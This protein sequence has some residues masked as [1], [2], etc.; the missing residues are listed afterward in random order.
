MLRLFICTL[1][2]GGF[3]AGCGG[4]GAKTFYMHR[5]TTLGQE[6]SDLQTAYQKGA[7]SEEVYE[8]QRAK[9]LKGT[10]AE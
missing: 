9:L 7:I 3:L 10:V 2:I 5:N 1:L 8:E 6:L 4:G